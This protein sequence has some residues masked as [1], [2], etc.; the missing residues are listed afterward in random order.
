MTVKVLPALDWVMG[1]PQRQRISI[2]TEDVL[3]SYDFLWR[4]NDTYLICEITR[5]EDESIMWRGIISELNPVEVK[6][7]VRYDVQF[8]FVAIEIDKLH[9]I[10]EVWIFEE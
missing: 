1:F 7:P 10:I 5:T 4:W 8:T 2:S 6:D 9:E 3:K